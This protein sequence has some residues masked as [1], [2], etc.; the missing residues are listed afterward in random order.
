MKA[1]SKI[2]KSKNKQKKMDTVFQNSIE[3]II[4]PQI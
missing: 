4:R 2:V 1:K 3:D